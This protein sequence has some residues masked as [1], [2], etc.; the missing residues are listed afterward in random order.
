MSLRYWTYILYTKS[1]S[2]NILEKEIQ[3]QKQRRA[4]EH[5]RQAGSAVVSPLI[6]NLPDDGHMWPKHVAN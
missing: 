3:Q 4:W 2:D 5:G 1:D 6:K